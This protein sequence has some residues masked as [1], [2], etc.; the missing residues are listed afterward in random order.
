MEATHAGLRGCLWRAKESQGTRTIHRGT[1]I[2]RSSLGSFPAHPSQWGKNQGSGYICPYPEP[3]TCS[4]QAPL[5]HCWVA[6]PL[7]PCGR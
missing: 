3:L 7:S 6:C 5:R 4:L 1:Q 2:S